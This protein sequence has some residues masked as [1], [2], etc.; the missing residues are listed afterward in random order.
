M[1]FLALP[2]EI[3]CQIISYLLS[4]RDVAALSIQCRALHSMCD[5]AARKKYHQI[6][7]TEGESGVDTAFEFLLDILKRPELALYVRHLENNTVVTRNMDYKEAEPMRELST[8]EMTLFRK[9]V[10]MGGFLGAKEDR[11][12]NMLMQRMDNALNQFSGYRERDVFATF[13]TQALA[14]IIIAVSPNIVSIATTNPYC[15]FSETELP[16]DQILRQANSSTESTP[17]LRNLRS[18]YMISKTDSTWEDGRFYVAM[19]FYDFTRLFDH[20]PSIE[21]VSTDAMEENDIEHLDFNK[22]SCNISSISIHHSSVSSIYLE[23]LIWSRKALK[24]IRYSIGGRASNDGGHFIFNP[25]SFIKAICDHKETL[26]VI[27][28]DVEDDIAAFGYDDVEDVER[29]LNEYGSPYE[30]RSDEHDSEFLKAIWENSG[31]LREFVSLRKL[32]LGVNFLL[33]LAKGVSGSSDEIKDREILADCLPDSLEY[34]CIR[35]YEKG[36]SQD[37]DEQMDGLMNFWKSGQSQLKEIQ[38]IEETIPNA[39]HVSDPD[40]DDHLLWP[41]DKGSDS[42]DEEDSD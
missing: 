10:R 33:Y 14:A 5:M 27:D 2:L 20:L 7:I 4:N 21:A 28:I 26:E 9:A 6:I 11:V 24:E 32:S 23:R 3:H 35:G 22:K 15:R 17:Y 42:E 31:S 40:G 39:S 19:D 29:S 1:S 38:G 8:E 30:V 36:Q 18:V 41:F 12:V 13:V 34:L 37:H 25:K 16:L